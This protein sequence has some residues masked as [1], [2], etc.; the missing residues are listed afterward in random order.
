MPP[1]K[2]TTAPQGEKPAAT[3][4]QKAAEKTTANAADKSNGDDGKKKSK[5]KKGDKVEVLFIRSRSKQGFRRCGMGFSHKGHGVAL[6]L[7]TR[8]QIET[9]TQEPNLIVEHGEIDSAD[10][11]DA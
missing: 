11:V 7:L 3:A 9:L 5:P 10:A 6:E 4:E 8:K 2:N 1:E